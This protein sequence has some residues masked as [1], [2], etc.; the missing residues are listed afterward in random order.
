MIEKIDKQEKKSFLA[1]EVVVVKAI[2]T[3]HS[4]RTEV[5]ALHS[6]LKF[7]CTEYVCKGHERIER[8]GV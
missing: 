7:V 3:S 1:T 4:V 5:S 8:F 2:V 6:V